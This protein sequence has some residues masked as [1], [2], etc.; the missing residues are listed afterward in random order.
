MMSIHCSQLSHHSPD[1][2]LIIYPLAASKAC[3]DHRSASEHTSASFVLPYPQ[4]IEIFRMIS[5]SWIKKHSYRTEQGCLTKSSRSGDQCDL[6]SFP[7][8]LGDKMRLIY[9][10][11][12]S[13]GKI[14]KI[15]IPDHHLGREIWIVLKNV[16]QSLHISRQMLFLF[17]QLC[18][19]L[20]FH[21]YLLPLG[22]FH[23]ITH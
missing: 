21:K 4:L 8:P 22:H 6:R 13:T 14:T 3:G 7:E 1:R 23:I 15:L 17:L 18:A 11:L 20:K 9:I 5:I 12:L 10:K 2:L 16:L 19:L